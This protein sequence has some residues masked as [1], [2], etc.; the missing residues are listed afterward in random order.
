MAVGEPAIT[1]SKLSKVFGNR[2]A[3]DKVTFD[4]PQGAFL[5]IFGPNGAG[6]T[7]L[8][9]V[10]STLS[11]ATSGTASLMGIDIKEEPDKVRD[12][13]GL[14]SHNSMLYLDLT[15]EE[16]LLFA[17]QLYGVENPEERVLE[18]LEAVELKHRRLD[19]VRTFSRGMTQRLSI[20]RALIHDPGVVFLD[21]PYS[22]LDPHAVEIF[23]EL[24]GQ[25][26]ENRT[27]VMVSHDLQKGFAMCTHALVLAKGRIVA[28]DEK[29][30]LDFEE[31]SQ[32]Y[33]QTVG[34]GVA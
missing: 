14:I 34:M 12:H 33:R 8:L 19:T 6:K 21:E 17:A 32:I 7:T 18:L 20:A 22:G 11:R 1:T 27:F 25:V 26:R 31:F 28:F 29:E 24:I 13:I 16:N 4:L 30:N 23:D 9:R 3:V 5:S 2:K 10:L 15:A